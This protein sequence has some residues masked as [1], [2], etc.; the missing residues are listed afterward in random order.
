MFACAAGH[1]QHGARVGCHG[2]GVV[3]ISE[4][5]TG[6]AVRSASGSGGSLTCST[7]GPPHSGTIGVAQYAGWIKRDVDGHINRVLHY[8]PRDCFYWSSQ[9]GWIRQLA[10]S[11]HRGDWVTQCIHTVL[12]S[13]C[14]KVLGKYQAHWLMPHPQCALRSA[15]N[16]GQVL[17]LPGKRMLID[18]SAAGAHNVVLHAADICLA[19]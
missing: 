18:H 11:A 4:R 12:I 13:A 7:G 17:H 10:S 3:N 1:A 15:I 6:P 5:V 2:A 19:L 9:C 14:D 8:K 16:K